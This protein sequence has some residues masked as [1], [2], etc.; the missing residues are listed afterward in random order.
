MRS[1]SES[2]ADLAGLGDLEVDPVAVEPVLEVWRACRW[3]R[4]TIDGTWSRN[5]ATWFGDRVREQHADAADGQQQEQVHRGDRG[6]AREARAPQQRHER[7]QQQRDQPGDDEQQQHRAGRARQRPGAEQRERQHDELDPARH[8]HRLDPRGRVLLDRA[9][10]DRGFLHRLR[11]VFLGVGFR[12]SHRSSV[13]AQRQAGRIRCSAWR[14]SSSSATSSP[15]PVAARSRS[16]CPALREEHALD[17]VVVNGEN[18]AGGIGITPKH[19]DE[20]FA[21]GVDVITL[22]NHT[23]RHR[24]VWP[25]LDEQRVHP[26]ARELP[27]HAAGPRD[28]RVRARG[29]R[30]AR[31]RE[32]VGQPVHAGRRRPPSPRSTRRCAR[33]RG[34]DHVL[35]DMHAEATSEKV[36]MGW[37]LDGRVTAVVGTHTHVPTADARVLPGGT[38]YVTDVGMTGAR[39]GVIGVKREQSIAVFR[40]HMPMRYDSSDEDPWLMAVVIRTGAGSRPVAG[41]VDRDDP[42]PGEQRDERQRQEPDEV[43]VEPVLQRELERDQR[44]GAE[45]GDGDRVA[46]AG[47]EGDHDG[48]DE[49]AR[50]ARRCGPGGRRGPRSRTATRGRPGSRACGRRTCPGRRRARPATSRAPPSRREP[51]G[52]ERR[53]PPPGRPRVG[54]EHRREHDRR[55]LRQ[56]RRAPPPPRARPAA[57]ARASPRAPAAPR[58]R[59]WC[60]SWR[61]AA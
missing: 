55:E 12:R 18:A 26:P 48:E 8:D 2:T 20:L 28:V 33:S 40:T 61:R 29:R 43:E 21:A 45:R 6:A 14:P 52:G 49:R 57:R 15:P 31:R 9:H 46:A 27:A 22:G 39:G 50:P 25:Y 4:A 47:D 7:V 58:A 37:F 38:A 17:F 24:E 30:H 34:A 54:G 56:R 44:G 60:S 10:R 11:D 32:P 16:C 13:C 41:R 23:Y 36:A 1:P 19:A 35:V 3:R 51:R 53:G 59:R 5:A 42:A